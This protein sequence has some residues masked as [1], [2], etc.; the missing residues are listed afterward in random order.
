MT[1]PEAIAR[2]RELKALADS[3]RE[4]AHQE[5]D[6]V[7]LLLIGDDDVADAFIDIEKWYA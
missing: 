1:I 2:L 3:D 4:L 6:N 7:L 5:A